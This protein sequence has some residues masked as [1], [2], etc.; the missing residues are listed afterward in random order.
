MVFRHKTLHLTAELTGKENTTRNLQQQED[1]PSGL[2]PG[3]MLFLKSRPVC[4]SVITLGGGDRDWRP[5]ELWRV[6][7]YFFWTPDR[8]CLTS[9]RGVPPVSEGKPYRTV[10]G[11]PVWRYKARNR[12]RKK[13]K[14]NLLFFSYSGYKSTI[15]TY[16]LDNMK[17]KSAGIN[18][19]FS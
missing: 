18:Y 11:E 12:N 16:F 13:K 17:P 5:L 2:F 9:L 8:W 1:G 6:S 14:L 7:S 10:P 15:N 4:N 19:L 3:R